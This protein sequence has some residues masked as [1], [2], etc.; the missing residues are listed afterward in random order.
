MEAKRQGIGR[1]F[2]ELL[3]LLTD[4]PLDVSVEDLRW[5]YSYTVCFDTIVV[6]QDFSLQTRKRP[7]S[8]DDPRVAGWSDFRAALQKSIGL[9]S[10]TPV[11]SGGMCLKVLFEERRTRRFMNTHLMV[12]IMVRGGARRR[13]KVQV[14]LIAFSDVSASAML[15]MLADVEVMMAVYGSGGAWSIFMRPLS[16]AVSFIPGWMGITS[17]SS[18]EW[19]SSFCHPNV[20]AAL[21]GVT[22]ILHITTNSSLVHDNM[23]FC[24]EQSLNCNLQ[25][26]EAEFNHTWQLSQSLV[27]C[28]LE[29]QYR[30]IVVDGS[31]NGDY[32]LTEPDICR[33]DPA[34]N[35]AWTT[36]AC[37]AV[38][39]HT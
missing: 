13:L 22:S 29:E 32:T 18:L 37:Q 7:A 34:V 25:L 11:T 28:V 27:G 35:V 6:G 31:C 2:T 16:V 39:G 24:R 20:G 10:P 5:R 15:C 3:R 14:K 17:S 1:S 30:M 8:F 12:D 23:A 9:L 4:G 38:K 19:L 33:M 36:E 26:R 21:A